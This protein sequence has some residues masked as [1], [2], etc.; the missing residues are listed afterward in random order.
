MAT[1]VE[2][3]TIEPLGPHDAGQ[4]MTLDEF[5][6]AHRARPQGAFGRNNG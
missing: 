2:K 5:E 3:Q 4:P 1:G 6:A